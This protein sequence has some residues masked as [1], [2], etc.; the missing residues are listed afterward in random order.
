MIMQLPWT[1][2]GRECRQSLCRGALL[3]IV[4]TGEAF[5]IMMGWMRVLE[6]QSLANNMDN[7]EW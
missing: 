6:R 4:R 5:C 2:K 7:F 1:A 3:V